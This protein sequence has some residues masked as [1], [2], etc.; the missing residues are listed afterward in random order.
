MGHGRILNGGWVCYRDEESGWRFE[1]RNELAGPSFEIRL[2][3]KASEDMSPEVAEE[4]EH[5]EY[6]K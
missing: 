3:G 6:Y 4:A 1:C 5:E 2:R